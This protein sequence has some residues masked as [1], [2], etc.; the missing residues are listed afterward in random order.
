MRRK[1]PLFTLALGTLIATAPLGA[2]NIA[3]GASVS[4]FGLFGTADGFGG[5][6][7]LGNPLASFSSLTDGVSLAEGTLWCS[8]TIFWD[9]RVSGSESNSLIVDLGSSFAIGDVSLQGDNNDIYTVEMRA[10]ASDPWSNALVFGTV[11]GAGMRTR[12]PLGGGGVLARELRITAS[13]GDDWFSVSEL[14]V[15]GQAVPEPGA[16]LLLGAGALVGFLSRRRRSS[17][18]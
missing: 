15:E 17:A 12:D 5:C 8:N 9:A 18:D 6:P 11:F 7:D 10:S 14:T 16:V 1:G 4:G 13:G 2:Q 3:L